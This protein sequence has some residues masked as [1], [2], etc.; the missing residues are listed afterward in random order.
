LQEI[1]AVNYSNES[2]NPPSDAYNVSCHDESQEVCEDKT[3]D[4]GNGYA[5]VVQECH[6]ESTQYCNYTVDEWNTIQT[7]TLQGNDLFPVY[8]APN[9]SSDQR[10]GASSETLTVTFNTDDG[11]ETYSPG[12]VTEFQQFEVGSVWMLKMNAMGGILSVEK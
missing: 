11:Q 4:K 1:Q 5:E 2:G 12:S 3:V 8:D 7:Y 10:L 9:Y 6:T